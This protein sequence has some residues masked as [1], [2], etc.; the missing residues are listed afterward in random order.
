MS[1]CKFQENNVIAQ[2]DHI[3]QE[4]P[5]CFIT[6]AQIHEE[7]DFNP[8]VK[9]A[10]LNNFIKNSSRKMSKMIVIGDQAVGKT[11]LVNRFCKKGFQDCYSATIG[12]D[13]AIQRFKVL[14]SLF[15]L[16]MWDTAGQ[17]RFQSVAAAYYRGAQVISVVFDVS[18][19]KTL[20]SAEQWLEAAKKEN[21]DTTKFL[22]FLVGNKKDVVAPSEYDK[23]E[24]EAIKVAKNLNA[25]FW[26]TSAMTGEN[27]EKFFCRVA[28]MSFEGVVLRELERRENNDAEVMLQADSNKEKLTLH[29]PLHKSNK[30]CC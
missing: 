27:V 3:I 30:Q 8:N 5:Q 7:S 19:R 11:C 2:A 14:N 26:S 4:F 23:I 29:K 15:S 20:V 24:R 12:V 10:C 17:D 25:E 28:A 16:Q 1:N 13:F 6:K 22:V 18:D 9:K 21:E